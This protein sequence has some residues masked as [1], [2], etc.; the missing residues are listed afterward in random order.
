MA[1][2]IDHGLIDE[3]EGL[4]ARGV[5]WE[6]LEQL[7]LE[8]GFIAQYIEGKIRSK[9]DLIQKLAAAICHF[10]KRQDTWFRRMERNGFKI[11]WIPRAD[12]AIAAAVVE[13]PLLEAGY[14]R[15]GSR[16]DR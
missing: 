9:N 1:E 12:Y 7:G 14:K 16:H 13:R 6:R 2:R 4:H 8:Y 11:Y 10:A 5:T 3:V 15:A